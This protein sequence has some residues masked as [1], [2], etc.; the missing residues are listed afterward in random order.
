MR[1]VVPILVTLVVVAPDT[2]RADDWFDFRPT[3]GIGAGSPIDLR[4]LNESAAGENGFITA[5]DG[6]FVHEKSNEPVRF[7]AVNGPPHQM[8]GD[9]LKQ[10]ARLLAAYGVNLVR[11][12]GAVFNERGEVDLKKVRHA[13]EVVAA[14]K[15]EGIYT[16]FSIYFPLWFKP[17]AD[18]AWLPGYDGN[19]HPFAALQFN[20]EFQAKH[21][22]WFTALLTTPDAAGH[23]LLDDPAVFG[24]EIQNEDSFFFWTFEAKNLPER[25]LEILEQ[26]FGA[27]LLKKY[28]SKDALS[29]AWNGAKQPGDKPADGRFAFRPLWNIANERTPRDRDTATFLLEVQ[30]EFYR[31]TY[32]YLRDLGFRGLIH[33]S[34]WHTASPEVLGPL[35]K[36]SYTAGDFVDRHGYFECNHKGDNAAWSMRDGHTY[37]DRSALRFDPDEPG[38]PKLFVHPVM[39]P[40]YDDKPSMI[41]ETTFTRPNRYRSE[42]PLYFAAYGA[43]QDSDCL[44]HFAFDGDQWQVKPNYFMQQWTLATPAMLGQFPAA[45]LLYRKGLI[46]AGG[47]VADVR[48][49]KGDLVQLKG[50][51]LPQDAAFDELRLKDVPTGTEV[52]P[53]QRIDPLVH[54]VGRARVTFTDEPGAVTLADLTKLVDHKAQVVTSDTRQLRLD[55]GR[56]VLTI[57]APRAQGVSG[58]LASAGKVD[59]TDITIE[60]PLDLVHVVAVS[61]DDEPLAKSQ[62]IL[63]QVMT[64]ERATD[65]ATQSAGAGV[66]R[67]TSIGRDPWRVRRIEGTVSFKRADAAKLRVTLLDQNG[68]PGKAVTGTTRL[69]LAAE[70]LYYVIGL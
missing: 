10:C 42:A 54:Y 58:N 61:L 70:T 29:K 31:S 59:L 41:S 53:G 24:V 51:P 39:D 6:R 16:H 9:H 49:N 25:Q 4:F 65:F 21:R 18:L 36:L 7:W 5:R 33:G 40:Q 47:I 27:W 13:Q 22:A 37:S 28:G 45:A 43:L 32:Q 8:S 55:Y 64:E 57:N 56:G 50:T 19:R 48:L 20:P 46:D 1:F 2:V 35:E 38:K 67:I 68:Q 62:S 11:V 26:R 17:A 34:N 23:R 60:S 66:Q 3:H 14:M 63:L 15:A 69:G 44:V 30:T 52:K 12:H